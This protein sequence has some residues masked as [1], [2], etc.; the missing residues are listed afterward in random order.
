M[1]WGKTAFFWILSTCLFAC[2]F[3]FY[4][5]EQS[6]PI[7]T[8]PLELKPFKNDYGIM[9]HVNGQLK[10][11]GVYKVKIGTKVFELIEALDLGP[12]SSTDHLNLAKTLRDGQKI[13]IKSKTNQSTKLNIN[14]ATLKQLKSLPG[15][16]EVS[17]Q[18]IMT[19]RQVNGTIKSIDELLNV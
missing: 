8:H 10:N 4:F 17:A 2:P 14:F 16:G 15:I 9:V 12:E 7:T 19:F 13:V 5:L 11:S 1:K 6:Q 3:L 18:K